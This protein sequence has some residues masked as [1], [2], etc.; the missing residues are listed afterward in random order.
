MLLAE[1][2]EEIKSSLPCL[3]YENGLH[4]IRII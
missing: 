1:L 4:T 3:R 2:D